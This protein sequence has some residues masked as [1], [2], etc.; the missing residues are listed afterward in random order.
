MNQLF[1]G[2]NYE[3]QL[4][5]FIE[6]ISSSDGLTVHCRSSTCSL[7]RSKVPSQRR[8]QYL[9]GLDGVRVFR[10]VAVRRESM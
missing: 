2:R 8:T 3:S 4:A 1:I 5:L 9:L 7:K 10:S 6:L